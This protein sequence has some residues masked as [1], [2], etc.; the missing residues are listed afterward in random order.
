MHRHGIPAI[1]LFIEQDTERTPEPYKFYIIHKDQ[2][3]ASYSNLKSATKKYNE[4]KQEIGYKPTPSPDVG[5]PDMAAVMAE[6]WMS[7]TELYWSDS[8]SHRPTNK[9]RR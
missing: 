6:E 5:K 7:R 4:V 3:L 9:V 8:S 2:I 1:D